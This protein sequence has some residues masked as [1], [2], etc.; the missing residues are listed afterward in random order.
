MFITTKVQQEFA[1]FIR[2]N[3][4]KGLFHTSDFKFAE[5]IRDKRKW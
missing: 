3:N 4:N 2:H 5:C 1:K